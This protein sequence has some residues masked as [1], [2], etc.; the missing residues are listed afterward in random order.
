MHLSF[1]NLFVTFSNKRSSIRHAASD[2][3]IRH[4]RLSFLSAT[5][6]I[7]FVL[8]SLRPSNALFLFRMMASTSGES[9]SMSSTAAAASLSLGTKNDIRS[10]TPKLPEI[11]PTSKRLFLVRHG[12]VINPGGPNKAVFYGG[13]DVPLSPLGKL[14]AIA[15]AQ[16]LKDFD[17]HQVASSPLSRAVF[18]AQQIVQQAKDAS[19][20]CT[21]S[22]FIHD[23]FRE[24]NRGSWSGKTAEEIGYDMLERF[25]NCDLTVT[26]DGGGESYLQLKERVMEAYGEL[27][28]LTPS[29]KAS[30]LVS[31]L[32]VTRALLSDALRLPPNRMA[33]IKIATASITCIDYCTR[34]GQPIVHFQSWK[35]Q[36][37]LQESIDGAN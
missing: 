35:P 26:P 37:G 29:G 13:D 8:S 14:E 10:S 7:L 12:E 2:L 15:A 1:L 32:Q 5:A 21:D 24:L 4:S 20:T 9:R 34:G 6:T 11:L 27:L 23:G 22:I 30:A 28:K 31:H 16:Y 25:N 33:S 17:L 18:G 19:N 36:T 3:F